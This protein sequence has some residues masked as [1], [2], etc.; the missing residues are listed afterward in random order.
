M[1]LAQFSWYYL[2]IAPHLLLVP[3]LILS[4]RRGVHRQ[5]PIFTAYLAFE[6]IQF[7]A[8]FT[9]AR[10]ESASKDLYALVYTI[11]RLVLKERASF[12]AAVSVGTR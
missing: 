5:F 4:I 8:L 11:G 3:L 2:W 10:T 9:I 7:V 6:F 12:C 1:S